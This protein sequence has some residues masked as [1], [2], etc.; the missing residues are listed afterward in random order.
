MHKAMM[1]MVT[2]V[3]EVVSEAVVMVCLEEVEA[4]LSTIT[5]IRQDISLETV[6]TQIRH[7][8][9]AEQSIM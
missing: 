9:I 4:R 2:G 8:A 5:A 3:V 7:V 6:R 1:D